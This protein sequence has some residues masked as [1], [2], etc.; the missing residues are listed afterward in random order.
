MDALTASATL[1]PP[2]T[3]PP[4]LTSIV[5]IFLQAQRPTLSFVGT[6][7]GGGM[8]FVAVSLLGSLLKVMDQF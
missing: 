4:E 5:T 1:T 2:L 8:G 7:L 6:E 3:V